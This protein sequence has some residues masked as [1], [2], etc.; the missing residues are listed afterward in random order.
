MSNNG[1]ALSYVVEN[2]EKQNLDEY[3]KLPQLTAP[4]NTSEYEEYFTYDRAK[5]RALTSEDCSIVSL[6]LIQYA[7]YIQ[8]SENRIKGNMKSI[9]AEINR[10]IASTAHQFSGAWEF[11]REQAI[12]NKEYAK[13][14]NDLLLDYEQKAERLN[15]IAASI[16][17]LSD[18]FKN[19]KFD[20]IKERS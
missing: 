3:K 1:N 9:K 8:R 15:N 6:R 7:M 19:L 17:M 10:C 16:K 11:Q 14:L 13:K 4:G 2:H 5:L 18:Q 12:Q 20:K